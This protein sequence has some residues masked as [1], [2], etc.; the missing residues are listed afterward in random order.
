MSCLFPSGGQSTGASAS[1]SV[2]PMNS[3]GWF[4]L[5]LTGWISLQSKGLSRV[6]SNTTVQ[7][8]QFFSAQP[9]FG[10][11]NGTPLQ[12]SYLENPMDKEPGRLQSMGSLGVRYDWA[13]LLSLFTF[14]HWRRKWQP[15]PV[16]CLENS[17]DGGGWWAAVY[18]VT[19]SWTRLMRLRSS[20]GSQVSLD[21][22]FLHSS[23]LERKGNLF[24][25]LVIEGLVGLHRTVKLQLF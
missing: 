13:T 19:Q 9:C 5:G 20:S 12:Y 2:L 8:H 21:L 22:L 25:V 18:G 6:F 17:R 15:I 1:A 7:K 23:P 3:Q 11:G 14:M 4:P 16:S 24:W 10:E